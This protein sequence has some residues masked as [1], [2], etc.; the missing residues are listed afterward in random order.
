[1]YQLQTFTGD[2]DCISLGQAAAPRQ[3]LRSTYGMLSG[4]LPGSLLP[5]NSTQLAARV[6]NFSPVA[7]L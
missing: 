5:P 1:M 4:R 7:T 3:P 2:R 6:Q